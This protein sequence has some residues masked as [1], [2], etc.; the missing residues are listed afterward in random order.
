MLTVLIGVL[1]IGLILSTAYA[2]SVKYHINTMIKENAVIQGE[3][4]NLNVKIESASNI[5]IV[6]ARAT[7]ELG[8]LYPTAEQLVFID[9]TR[10]TVK[11][12]ALVLKEQAY[13]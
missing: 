7:V 3:I 2:A 8:M 9:G 10:E 1:C 5:Q 12:F 11:D 4:E 6:E 13:N